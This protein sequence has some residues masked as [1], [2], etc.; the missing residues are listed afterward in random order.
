MR[1]APCVEK[2]CRLKD[3]DKNNENCFNCVDRIR[4]VALIGPEN[5]TV[6]IESTEAWQAAAR[7]EKIP[8][9]KKVK[10]CIY[11]GCEQPVFSRSLCQNHYTKLIRGTILKINT[12]NLL[13]PKDV[14]GV[15]RAVI[16]ISE[17]FKISTDE[18]LIILIDEGLKQY[19]ARTGVK[20]Y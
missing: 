8:P 14:A 13:T 3:D 12:T 2:N 10:A 6:P 20:R 18:T 7:L 5:E 17:R 16:R 4:Y 9:T 11:P 1:S 15:L 19:A